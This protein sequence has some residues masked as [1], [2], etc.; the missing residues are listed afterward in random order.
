LR[1]AAP[2][3]LGRDRTRWIG[4]ALA[5]AFAATI[6]GARAEIA[7]ALDF[8]DR[9][10][11]PAA[12][13]EPVGEEPGPQP[14]FVCPGGLVG[15]PYVV[16]LVGRGSCEPYFKFTVVTGAVPPGLS[17]SSRGLISGTPTTAGRWTFWVRAQDLNRAD[18]GP[19]WCTSS[20]HADGEFTIAV[21][22][23]VVITTGSAPPA[24]IGAFYSLSLSAQMVSGPNQ[25][26]PPSGCAPGAPATSLCPLTWSIAQGRLPARLTLNPVSGLIWGTPNAEDSASF[27]VRAALDDGRATTRS[28]TITV[29]RPVSIG[30]PRSFGAPGVPTR[31]EVGVPFAAKLSAS[32]GTNT[33]SWSLTA[34]A[35][36]RGLSLADDGRIIGTPRTAGR[37]RATIHVTDGEGRGADHRADFRV[38]PRL[39][40]R[41]RTLPPGRVGLPYRVSL[42]T[43]GGFAPMAW[44]IETGALPRG[45]RFD[46][47]RATLTGTPTRAGTYRLMFRATD[48]IGAT[49]TRALV[50]RLA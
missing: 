23:G 47:A 38:A 20:A 4:F 10:P 45:L 41:T 11:C 44:R 48:A 15:T 16:Q 33:Y 30:A 39:A 8:D 43:S 37:F 14:P 19:D 13:Q 42:G 32:G 31:S 28:L 27:V 2:T 6:A 36:P 29:R 22:P 26:S 25:L 24:T 9:G 40:I 50:I 34:G 46:R 49:A 21:E 17:V 12:Y 5:L 1:L 3:W 7:G 35:L 18:G